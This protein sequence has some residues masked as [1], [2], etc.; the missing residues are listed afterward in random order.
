MFEVVKNKIKNELLIA[1]QLQQQK[2]YLL[3]QLFI[4]TSVGVD[5]SSVQ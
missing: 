1:N 5:S 3:Q 2:A 4:W